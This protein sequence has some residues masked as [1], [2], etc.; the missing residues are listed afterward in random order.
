[1]KG[2]VVFDID[3]TLLKRKP[4]YESSYFRNYLSK[5]DADLFIPNIGELLGVY[6]K[7]YDRYDLELLR[8]YLVSTTG[9]NFTDEMLLGWREV[10]R[11]SSDEVIC[12]AHDILEYLKTH[13]YGLAVLTNWFA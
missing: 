7:T 13:G 12:G 3:N 9:I 10:L 5:E 8:N 11:N 4:H 2:L 1:M 6:E